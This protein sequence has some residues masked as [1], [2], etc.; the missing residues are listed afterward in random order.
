M[1]AY[2]SF[3]QN[4]YVYGAQGVSANTTTGAITFG[5]NGYSAGSPLSYADVNGAVSAPLV[6]ASSLSGLGGSV[7]DFLDQFLAALDEQAT[8]SDD[9]FDPRNREQ[10]SLVVEGQICTP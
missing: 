5:P 8:F 2:N 3:T 10:D 7:A 6:P 9:P 4:S 1:S